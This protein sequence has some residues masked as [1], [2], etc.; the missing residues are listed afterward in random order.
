MSASG[1]WRPP[2]WNV[3]SPAKVVISFPGQPQSSPFSSA[4]GSSVVLPTAATLYAFDAEFTI[5]HEQHLT[6]TEHPVQT[7]A[8]ISDHAFINPARLIIDIG[9][10]DVMDAYYNPSTWQ[11]STSKSVSAYQTMLA[12]QFSRIPLQI[13]TRLR[14]YSNMIIT[15]LTPRDTVKTIGALKMTIEF[16]QIFIANISVVTTSARPQDTNNTDLGIVNPTPPTTAQESQ[17]NVS[18]LQGVPAVPSNA[19]GGGNWTSG[20]VDTLS[21]LPAGK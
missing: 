19:I 4:N 10:S 5:E 8:S 2:N 7:G 20:N 16:G 6:K 17:N 14:T 3:A 18:G 13:T 15:N 1:I 21:T 9:M 12:L 11:G